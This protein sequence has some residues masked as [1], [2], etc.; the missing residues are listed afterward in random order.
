[1]T[2]VVA[3]PDEDNVP[4]PLAPVA[5]GKSGT[6]L[7]PSAP[8]PAV[9]RRTALRV[10]DA[11]RGVVPH[12]QYQ[13]TRLGPAG[14]GGISALA[15]AAVVAGVA[16]FSLRAANESLTT[17][18]LQAQHRPKDPVT[19]EQGLTRVVTEF[20]TRTQMPAVI[21][22]LIQQAKAAGVEL[23]KGQYTCSPPASGAVGR[24]E[25]SF[26]VKAP[27]PEVR[28][29]INR[30][31]T[32]VPA[33]ALHKLSIERKVVGDVEVNADVRFTIFVRDR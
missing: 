13:L 15:A 1:V 16:L 21:G 5:P 32:N 24:Y 14:V 31:L 4:A 19:P 9:A 23:G 10:R 18:I 11:V 28:D 12:L 7:A 17:R 2:D 33:A 25:V 6:P 3:P 20:P 22:Q 26:P 8:V 27:Y 29:F 30:T